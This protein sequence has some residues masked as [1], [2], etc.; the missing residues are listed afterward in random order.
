MFDGVTFGGYSIPMVPTSAQVMP[1]FDPIAKPI[2]EAIYSG[3][4]YADDL[5]N[6]TDDP[7]YWSHSAR[8]TIRNILSTELAIIDRWSLATRVPNSG[9]HLIADNIHPVR[10]VRSLAGD[11]PQPGRNRARQ[12]AW[13]NPDNTLDLTVGQENPLPLVNLLI[14]WHLRDDEPIVHVSLPIGPWRYGKPTRVHW[15]E[16]LQRGGAAS[17]GDLVFEGGDDDSGLLTVTIDPTEAEA[18]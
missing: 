14:D 5:L 10:V 9:V 15:R 17:I 7:W 11:V 3:V 13:C 18:T 2:Y 6:Y 4:G 12:L 1:M 8:F 16:P